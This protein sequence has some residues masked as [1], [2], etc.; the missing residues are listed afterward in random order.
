[1]SADWF[2]FPLTVGGKSIWSSEIYQPMNRIFRGIFFLTWLNR[3]KA[4]AKK[5]MHL[6]PE[7]VHY[8]QAHR[9]VC[10]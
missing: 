5:R 7:E 3:F 1:M 2:M 6:G 4:G 9:G 8:I 10:M